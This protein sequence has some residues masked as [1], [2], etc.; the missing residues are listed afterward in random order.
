MSGHRPAKILSDSEFSRHQIANVLRLA[1]AGKDIARVSY[2]SELL[3]GL[4][5]HLID[6]GIQPM[7]WRPTGDDVIHILHAMDEPACRIEIDD[8]KM[9]IAPGDTIRVGSN[10]RAQLSD[11]VLALHVQSV[12]GSPFRREHPSHGSESFDEFNRQTIYATGSEIALERWK[13]TAPLNLELD[14]NVAFVV[15]FGHISVVQSGSVDTVGPGD[16]IVYGAGHLRVYPDGLAYIAI[17]R[18]PQRIT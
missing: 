17:I 15:L 13:L 14:R 4:G 10:S 12:N 18:R 1:G 7:I 11:G 5:W 3:Q 16:S 8:I 2:I 9:A 6:T